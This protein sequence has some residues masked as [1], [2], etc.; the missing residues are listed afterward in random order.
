MP[1]IYVLHYHSIEK[2][3]WSQTFK[4]LTLFIQQ[5]HIKLQWQ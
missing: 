1:V 3:Y 2:G 4:K 5:E